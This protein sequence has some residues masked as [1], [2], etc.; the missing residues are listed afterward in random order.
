MIDSNAIAAKKLERYTGVLKESEPSDTPVPEEDADGLSDSSLEA[1]TGDDEI[2]KEPSLSAEAI[3]KNAHKEAENILNEARL[4]ADEIVG[5]AKSEAESI[6]TNAR[7]E[8]FETG[9]TEAVKEAEESRKA[10][11][12]EKENLKSEYQKLLSEVEPKMVETICGVYRAIFGETLYSRKDVM[13]C[14]INKALM[15]IEGNDRVTIYVGSE[16]YDLLAGMKD[17]FLSC[18]S[19]KES[20]EILIKEGLKQG[21]AMIETSYGVI[22]CSIDTELNEL[23]NTLKLLSYENVD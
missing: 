12:S 14:L 11:E 13:L 22:D 7:N 18:S 17:S 9:H 8:G 6:K 5:Q 15:N 10:F 19:L 21:S 20:T 16:D 2:A 4:K 1:L 3:V 23:T